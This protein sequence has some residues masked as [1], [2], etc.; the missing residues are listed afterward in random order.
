M[1]EITLYGADG[2]C[3]MASHILLQ[4]LG[5][6]FRLVSMTLGPNGVE[7]VDG[8]VTHDEYMSIHP[9]G[10]VPALALNSTIITEG[11]AIFTIIADMD[12]S[13]KLLGST[14]LEKARVYEWLNWISGTVHGVGWAAFFRPERFVDDPALHAAIKAKGIKTIEKCNKRIEQR[15]DG[16][17]AVGNTMTVVDPYLYIFWRWS[18]QKGG[19]DMARYPRFRQ[20]A[21]Q[22]EGMASVKKAVSAEN[23]QLVFT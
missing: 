16:Q 9:N 21:M 20:L 15:I 2:S 17:Y 5:V 18:Q 7:A 3:S 4:E 6:P 22:V 1:A 12:P 8:T 10:Y 11:P 13:R 23:Q 14:S 19:F